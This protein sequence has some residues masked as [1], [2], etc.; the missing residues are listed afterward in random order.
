MTKRRFLQLAALLL[1]LQPW[2]SFT[3]LFEEF[4]IVSCVAFENGVASF[5]SWST[6]YFFS[7]SI[8]DWLIIE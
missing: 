4:C 5:S 8:L 7:P 6:H 2:L 1:L 3:L